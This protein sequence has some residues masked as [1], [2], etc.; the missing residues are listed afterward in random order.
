MLSVYFSR[1]DHPVNMANQNV[2]GC[3]LSGNVLLKMELKLQIT[4]NGS[5]PY[6]KPGHSHFTVLFIISDYAVFIE[7]L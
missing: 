4:Q 6:Y 7:I 3:L 5:I 1:T 2:C